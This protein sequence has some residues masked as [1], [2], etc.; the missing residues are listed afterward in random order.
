VLVGAACR[1][2]KQ[3]RTKGSSASDVDLTET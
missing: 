2:I 3:E 1:G